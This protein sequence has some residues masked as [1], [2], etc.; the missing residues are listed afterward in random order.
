VTASPARRRNRTLAAAA[1]GVLVLG[2]AP[3]L[4]YAG[5]QVLK[6]SKAGT[7][8]ETLD[9]V[10]FPSTPTAMVAVVDDQNLVISLAVLVM[11]PSPAIGQPATGGTIVAIPT[12][13]N[14]AQSADDP[15]LPIADSMINAGE[16]G[17]EL[18]LASL[19]RVSLT[20]G[21]A[22][23]R[24]GVTALLATI[25]PIDVTLPNDVVTATADG[26]TETLFVAGD[27]QLSPEEAASVLLAR[28]PAQPESGRLPNV[29]AVWNGVS[30]A[31]G[32][33]IAPAAP[34]GAEITS[35][36][37]FIT[38]FVAGPVQ[39]FNDLDTTPITG[40]LNP[41]DL[42]VGTLDVPSVVL[43]MASL[44][45][46]AMITPYD[47]LN[48][49]IENGLTQADIDAAGLV[50]VTPA[51]VTRDLVSRILFLQGN[52][53][54]VSS[55]VYTLES[56]EV[57]DTTVMFSRDGLRPVELDAITER[58]GDVDFQSPR[59]VFPLVDIVVV[60]GRTYLADMAAVQAEKNAAEPSGTAATDT[61]VTDGDGSTPDTGNSAVEP[62][63]TVSS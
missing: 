52:I 1:A 39:V 4:G 60:V 47:T 43:L 27:A 8:V 10:Q 33:G 63:D 57:P 46:S 55:A 29:Q 54:S 53:V 59:F 18:D 11:S 2:T 62:T 12:N 51:D 9:E 15:A 22:L 16:E 24:D 23:D 19:T 34:L 28:D 61:A 3:V 5:W 31:I 58:L 13:A 36:D 6:D 7:A 20:T 40:S 44:A 14:R 49:R 21:S 42:D 41:D 48:F 56:G 30:A 17:L 37:D 45:P 38:H 26:S 32:T 50:D 25:G 35:F